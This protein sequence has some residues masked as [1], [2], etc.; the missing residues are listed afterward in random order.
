MKLALYHSEPMFK[1]IER[2]YILNENGDIAPVVA[3]FGICFDAIPFYVA[4]NTIQ[5]YTVGSMEW[6]FNSSRDVW[7]EP[8]TDFY[9]YHL[10]RMEIRIYPINEKYVINTY[11]RRWWRDSRGIEFHGDYNDARTHYDKRYE[12]FTIIFYMVKFDEHQD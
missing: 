5:L 6:E 9:D 4:I 12:G 3:S 8:S 1:I 10:N 2:K 11:R 7:I